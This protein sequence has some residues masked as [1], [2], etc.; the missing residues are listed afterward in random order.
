[1]NLALIGYRGTG[2]STVARRL[3]L[4]LACDWVDADVE[5]E[6]R[7]GKS[8]AAIF[9][10]EG[11]AR[12][13]NLEA[14]VLAG[15]VTRDGVVLALGGGVVLRPDNRRQLAR[16][17][18]VVWLQASPATILRRVEADSTTA[19]R[20]PRLTTAGGQEE[21]V[22][23]LNEREPLYREC[24]Q[25]KIDTEQKTPAEIAGEIIRQ[26]HLSSSKELV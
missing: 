22:R 24:A 13:R 18:K 26:L 12:F 17:G 3:A 8:I 5:I 4:E 25:L 6:L 19:E 16:C 21:V 20:R 2:K 15:L 9:A 7:A 23:L 11:E 1:M 14:E 10:E